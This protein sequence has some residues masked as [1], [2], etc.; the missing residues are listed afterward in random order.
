MTRSK[1]YMH[2]LIA[3]A[4]ALALSACVVRPNQSAS[5]P[6]GTVSENTQASNIASGPY[7]YRG[8]ADNMAPVNNDAAITANVIQALSRVSGATNLQ[9]RTLN[10]VVTLSGVVDNQST[11]QNDIQVARQVPGVLR[12]DY[13]LEVLRR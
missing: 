12:V 13:D 9:V 8:T 3:T 5:N 4:A 10:G 2:I 11:A 6:Y 1:T 7:Y